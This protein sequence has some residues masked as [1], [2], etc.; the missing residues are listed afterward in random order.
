MQKVKIIAT[1]HPRLNNGYVYTLEEATGGVRYTSLGGK[2]SV[3]ISEASD[4]AVMF[5]VV[6]DYEH[7]Q[8]D[9]TFHTEAHIRIGERIAAELWRSEYIHSAETKWADAAAKAFLER[10]KSGFFRGESAE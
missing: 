7:I 10:W 8:A 3:F 5:E 2:H 6:K 1:D 9:R 4:Y